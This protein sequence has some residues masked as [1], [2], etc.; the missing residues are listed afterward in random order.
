MIVAW[1]IAG[2]AVV[3][4]LVVAGVAAVEDLRTH[5]LRNVRTGAIGGAAVVA[6]TMAGVATGDMGP[7][8]DSLI[9]GA[10]YGGPWL[11]LHLVDRRLVGFGDV[12]YGGV[13]GLLIGLVDVSTATWAVLVAGLGLVVTVVVA[14][15]R[16]DQGR[17][18]LGPAL[19]AGASVAIAI[20]AV[21]RW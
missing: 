9:G 2:L 17:A 8:G 18:A 3:A 13:L 21:G 5:R 4:G 7:M 16:P 14:R 11:A 15:R 1:S 20:G 10:V 19:L 6:A 12:K